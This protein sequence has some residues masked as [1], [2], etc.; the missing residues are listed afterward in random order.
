MDQGWKRR[1]R[2]CGV[3]DPLR[4]IHPTRCIATSPAQLSSL[5][6]YALQAN[7]V[8]FKNG[9]FKWRYLVAVEQ[10][11]IVTSKPA[12]EEIPMNCGRKKVRI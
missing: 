2:H 5:A 3:A 4:L 6:D 9:S 8:N 1:I 7:D 11:P 10:P 12:G